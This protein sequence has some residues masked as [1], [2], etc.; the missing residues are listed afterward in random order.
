MVIVLWRL[1]PMQSDCRT[2]RPK[3]KPGKQG[4]CWTTAPI[5]TKFAKSIHRTEKREIK[6]AMSA[7]SQK[8]SSTGVL[9]PAYSLRRSEKS[10][11]WSG[12]FSDFTSSR[13]GIDG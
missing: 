4:L 7:T 10:A 11:V 5:G 1:M 2:K 3:K 6:A 13:C 12:V 9:K 8:D